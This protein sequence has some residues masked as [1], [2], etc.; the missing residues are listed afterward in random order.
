[1]GERPIPAAGGDPAAVLPARLPLPQVRRHASKP[2][3]ESTCGRGRLD[4]ASLRELWHY[5]EVLAAFALRAVKVK[6]KQAAVGIAWAIVQPMLAALLFSLFLGRLS[7]VGSEGEPYLLF[8][9]AGVVCW[10]F[11]SGTASTAMDSVV[12]DAG[13]LRK[14]YF[15]REV[16]PLAS[17]LAG[18]VDYASGLVTL[19]VVAALYGHYPAPSWVLLPL[20]LLILVLTAGAVGLATSGANVYYRDIRYALPFF[21]Q[22]GLFASPVVW[23]LST[24]PSSWQAPYAILNPIAGAI[25]AERAIVVHGTW[26]QLWVSLGALAWSGVL[27]VLGYAAFKRIERG[28]SDR[29]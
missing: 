7:N 8:A 22:L 19:L 12:Q 3:V 9:L 21:F 6:Y 25:D 1:M 11:F 23:S 26:P 27:L 14:V 2:V 24:I 4:A 5:R 17:L 20:P 18:L 13:L 28:F 15:P 10:T 16:L 29:V